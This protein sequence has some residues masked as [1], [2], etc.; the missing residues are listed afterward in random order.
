MASRQFTWSGTNIRSG[1]E[2]EESTGEK[3]GFLKYGF[4]EPDLKTLSWASLKA[5][6]TKQSWDADSNKTKLNE[7]FLTDICP[8]RLKMFLDC[9]N[10]SLQRTVPPSVSLLQR[11]FSSPVSCHATGFYPDRAVMFWRKDGKEIDEVVPHREILPNNDGTF[12]M[13][14]DLNVL[15]VRPEDWSRYECVFQVSDFKKNILTKVF[16]WNPRI[17]AV[18]TE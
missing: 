18:T 1:C 2:Y 7:V 12:Q 8:E 6:A 5:D 10:S 4:I 3:S 14:V 9:G 16:V 11:T 13:S 15:S 17:A